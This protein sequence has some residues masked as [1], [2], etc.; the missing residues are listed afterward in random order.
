MQSARFMQ[1]AL[2]LM[3]SVV[4]LTV[5]LERI[6]VTVDYE[7]KRKSQCTAPDKMLLFRVK[8]I[9]VASS[10]TALGLLKKEAENPIFDPC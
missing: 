4:W 8:I 5:A 10:V 1:S 9:V 7:Y 3:A 6:L 2:A